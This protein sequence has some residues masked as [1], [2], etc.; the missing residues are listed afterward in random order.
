LFETG[1]PRSFYASVKNSGE[2]ENL[3]ERKVT[4]VVHQV[5]DIVSLIIAQLLGILRNIYFV[6]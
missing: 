5:K 2:N 4:H 3:S 1:L 6:I